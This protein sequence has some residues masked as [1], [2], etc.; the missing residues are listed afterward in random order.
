MKTFFKKLKYL[1]FHTHK[2]Q[3][4]K[5][6]KIIVPWNYKK[7]VYQMSRGSTN[8]HFLP[9]P[10]KMRLHTLSTKLVTSKSI[11]SPGHPQLQTRPS[12]R[13]ISMWMS[14]GHLYLARPKPSSWLPALA[15]NLL[16]LQFPPSKYI[17]Y[18]IF[19][20]TLTSVSQTPHLICQQFYLLPFT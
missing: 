18:S 2:S 14:G 10:A 19:L 7:L 4:F 15:A 20:N 5:T 1:N 16:L 12:T 11:S 3:N 17:K 9:G 13:S 8:G 6:K